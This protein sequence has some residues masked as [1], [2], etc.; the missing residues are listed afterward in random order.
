MGRFQASSIEGS[1]RRF[2]VMLGIGA[3]AN[4]AC[5]NLMRCDRFW[6][7]LAPAEAANGLMS[8]EMSDADELACLAELGELGTS[9]VA[10]EAAFGGG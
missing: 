1:E 10:D 2:D 7:L 9:E 6:S 5:R 8:G 3:C 4:C